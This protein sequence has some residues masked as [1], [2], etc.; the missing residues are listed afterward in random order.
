[1]I[2]GKNKK[3]NE[4]FKLPLRAYLLYIAVVTFVLTGV[5]FSKYIISTSGADNA[6]VATFGDL[7]LYELNDNDTATSEQSFAIIPGA[8][9]TK[10]PVVNFGLKQKTEMAAYVFVTVKTSGWKFDGDDTYTVTLPGEQAD[11]LSWSVNPNWTYLTETETGGEITA[12]YYSIVPPQG[13]LKNDEI[14]KES[15]IAV[16]E[17]IRSGDMSTVAEAAGNISFQG[18]AV[19]IQG[20]SGPLEAWQSVSAK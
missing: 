16:S 4:R 8:D 18:Y 6:R 10:K 1:M 5:T 7:E 2:F 12:V 3:K 14:I 19:Q 15:K 13:V 11:A 9:I 17:K 20:F